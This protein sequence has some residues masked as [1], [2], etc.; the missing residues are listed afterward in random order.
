MSSDRPYHSDLRQEQARDTRLRIRTSARTLFSSK[1]FGATTVAEIAA[2]AGVSPQTIYSV[3]GSKAGIVRAMLE[4][5]EEAAGLKDWVQRIVAEEDPAEQ[6]RLFAGWMRSLVESS[7]PVIRA[8]L[9]ALS[10]RDVAAFVAEGDANR[11]EGIQMLMGI[12]AAKG[13]LRPGLDQATAVDRMWLLTSVPLH[14]A[15]RDVLG[16]SAADHE[17]WLAAT[18]QREILG[19]EG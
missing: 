15:S 19:E 1:G 5:I 17:T 13:A 18:L 16:W 12:L 4:E 14:L 8:A 9:A 11:R 10:D 6:L 7:E 2:S 3:F